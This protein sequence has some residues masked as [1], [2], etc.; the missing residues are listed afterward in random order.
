MPLRTMAPS[1]PVGWPS[2]HQLHDTDL[3]VDSGKHDDDG[4]IEAERLETAYGND[5]TGSNDPVNVEFVVHAP[6]GAINEA[7]KKRLI[8]LTKQYLIGE[9]ALPYVK[10]LVQNFFIDGLQDTVNAGDNLAAL[11]LAKVSETLMQIAE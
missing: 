3:R 8:G 1:I 11:P 10:G 7:L 5:I 6:N 4:E 2:H 9:L